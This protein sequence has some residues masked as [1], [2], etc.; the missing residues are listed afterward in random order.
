LGESAEE[1]EFL[2]SGTGAWRQLLAKLG[3][4]S[5]DWTAP[6]TGPLDYIA[7][8]GLLNDRLIAVHCVQLTDGELARL[9]DAG[10]TVVTCPRSNRW[11]GAGL[12]PVERFYAS[13]VRVAVGTDSLSSVEDLNVFEELRMMRELAPGV[14][15]REILASATTH[16]ADA[17]GFGGE[18]GTL[19][20][21]K[22]AEMI[23]VS[24]PSST[25]DVE[26]YLLGGI[27]PSMITWVSGS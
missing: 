16:G 6:A 24:V 11:T 19:E 4:W 9:A 14:A 27:T 13:G 10:A 21:G 8:H 22:R 17:L 7:A 5:D 25:I 20:P 15:A 23:A 18:L 1:V 12:P 26:E 2:Q 3:V